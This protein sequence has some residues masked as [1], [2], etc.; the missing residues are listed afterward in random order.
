MKER[1]DGS[2]LSKDLSS[3]D[4]W[5]PASV[6]GTVHQ[7][8]MAAGRIPDPFIGLN[9]L[10]VQWVGE[11]DWLYRC[12]FDL[13]PDYTDART[14]TLC[15][16]G[17]DTFATVWLNGQ[18]ILVSDNMFV[19]QRVPVGRLLQEGHN[20]LR[21]LFE[22]AWWR[23]KERE[24]QHGVSHV[25]NGDASRVYVRKAQYHYG[26]D[27]GPTLLTAGPWRA[28]RLEAY[29]ARIAELHCPV[30]VSAELDRSTLPVTVDVEGQATAAGLA[31]RL[32]L[33]DPAGE[34][35]GGVALPVEGQRLTHTFEVESPQ[36]WWPNSFGK[37][38]L[39][40][41]VATL[42]RE[43][44]ELDRRAL[45]LGMRH[46]RL[47]QE[48]LEEEP[49]TS[50]FFEVNNVPIF[51]GGA[52]WIPADS[53]IP[54]IPTER[55][56]ALLQMAADANMAMVRVW[57]GGIYE[58]EVFYDL[59]DELGLLVWQDFMFAC[60]L[61]PAYDEFQASVLAEA[62][63]AVRR[64]RHHPSLALWCGNNE[65]YMLAHSLGR[66]DPADDTDLV[67]SPFPA[68]ALYERLLPEVCALLDPVTPYWPGSAYGGENPN[69]GT[70][71]DRHTWDVWHGQMAP[72]QKYPEY[73][74][75]FVSEFGMQA[76]PDLATIE[77]FA[78]P[79]ERYPQSR[80]MDFHNKAEGGPRRLAVYLNDTLRMPIDL[81]GVVYATQLVQAEALAAAIRGWRRR[82]AGP[83]HYSVAGALIWQLNDCWPATSWAVVDYALR[84]K[85]AYYV[86][87]RELAP[88]AVALAD[89][90][91]GAAV[92]AVNGTPDSVEAE[93]RLS[94]WTLDGDSGPTEHR[95]L[96]LPPNRA[97][98][99]GTF[100]VDENASLVLGA[101]LLVDGNV[102]SRAALWPQPFKYLTLPD[103]GLQIERD[104]E[105]L[106]LRVARPAK[107]VWLSAGDGVSWS[108]NMLDLLP[109]DNQIV[110]AH[111]LAHR[112]VHARY[113][114]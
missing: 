95:K 11:R 29:D 64:L 108:D 71:G 89:V 90:K 24:V 55:Y 6:P 18:K 103:P 91:E 69:D 59:C 48:P 100:N 62:E 76:L 12:H 114:S 16:D 112:P 113:L 1:K 87:A 74:G 77:S 66:Y 14:I 32:A 84:P 82:F 35:V 98:E 10:D 42:L 57:G 50:F 65:D 99:L 3:G 8:L 33:Y 38:P 23:G 19:P 63:A 15:F 36:L 25:W 104:G 70:V 60:G 110:V 28:V 106:R 41:L 44:E 30:E 61:Y 107:G 45:R 85:A 109:D 96:L 83:N 27:W 86:V 7:D 20:E 94:S 102:V 79:S 47:R 31:L 39:Y 37:Q 17:L 54:R 105:T 40:R 78:E 52:N 80:T 4:G 88:L 68:R 26:W 97:T 73:A 9:E 5:I 46:L 58:E 75:R 81:E 22:S 93:L 43:E 53:F 34:R 67:A 49:G 51:G 21:I 13:S 101:R 72:Y 2:P 92:W 56:R 111:G